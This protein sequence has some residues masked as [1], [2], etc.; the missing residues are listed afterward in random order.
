MRVLLLARSAGEWWQQ[1]I[2]ES[3]ALLSDILAAISPMTLGAIAGPSGQQEVFR[4]ALA[5]FARKLDT[6]CPDAG[7]PAVGPDAVALVVHAAALLAVLDHRSGAADAAT[8]PAGSPAGV[9]GRL[10]GHEA[11]YWQQSQARYGLALGPALTDRV[12]TAGTLSAPMTRHR[13]PGCWPGSM[14]WPT[15]T[16]AAMPPGGSMTCTRPLIL[17]RQ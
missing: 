13:P 7:L 12:V 1:L 3:A 2:S 17:T 4:H 5:A 11:R 6:R 16:C 15:R 14:T 8:G 9:I 10:L